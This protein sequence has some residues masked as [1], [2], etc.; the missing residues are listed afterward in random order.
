MQRAPGKGKEGGGG[1]PFQQLKEHLMNT[2]MLVSPLYGETL[3][4]YLAIFDYTS[5]AVVVAEREEG[6]IPVCF[7]SHVLRGAK[8][9]YTL[10][11][12]VV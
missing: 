10:I 2:S 5:S 12:K 7:V 4:V 11:E 6:Q 3:F 9:R 8:T 1:K